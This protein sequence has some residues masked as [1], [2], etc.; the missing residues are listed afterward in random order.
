[1][2]SEP[3]VKFLK[4][5]HGNMCFMLLT[6][7]PSA[8]DFWKIKLEESCSSKNNFEICFCK[9]KIQFVQLDFSNLC[10]LKTIVHEKI[11]REN[12]SKILV[13]YF[14]VYVLKVVWFDNLGH[15]IISLLWMK[16]K[17]IMLHILCNIRMYNIHV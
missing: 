16:S 17:Q 3:F 15:Q 11:I 7:Y 9:S 1:M 5:F 4:Y 14:I 6:P 12:L 10:E 2:N 8:L 13:F